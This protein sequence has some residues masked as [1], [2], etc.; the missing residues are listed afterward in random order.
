MQLEM[1][2]Y[3]KPLMS[4]FYHLVVLIPQQVDINIT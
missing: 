4:Y 3:F 1:L 2:L